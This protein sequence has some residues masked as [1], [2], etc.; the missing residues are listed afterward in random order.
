MD[1]GKYWLHL[2]YKIRRIDIESMLILP[3]WA[4]NKYGALLDVISMGKKSVLRTLF[5]IT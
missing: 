5:D 2:I 1:F 3:R 4:E